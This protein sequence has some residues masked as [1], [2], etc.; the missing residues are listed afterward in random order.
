MST[1][2]TFLKNLRGAVARPTPQLVPAAVTA[3]AQSR[4]TC[5]EHCNYSDNYY[6]DKVCVIK[7]AP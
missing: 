6:G 4:V 2:K 1:I 7:C 3:G 5:S